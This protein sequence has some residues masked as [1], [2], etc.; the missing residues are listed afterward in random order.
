LYLSL[1]LSLFL[2]WPSCF[3]VCIFGLYLCLVLSCLGLAVLWWLLLQTALSVYGTTFYVYLSRL[4]SV[5]FCLSTYVFF[6]NIFFPSISISYFFSLS[7]LLSLFFY[8]SSQACH[9]CIM[10][11]SSVCA[12]I[13]SPFLCIFVL[14]LRS[15]VRL[16]SFPLLHSGILLIPVTSI[17]QNG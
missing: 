8:V 13:S 6:L 3:F 4:P 15:F 5:S 9:L 7:S 2:S 11:R 16:L 1:S 12:S 10:C 17:F 14:C